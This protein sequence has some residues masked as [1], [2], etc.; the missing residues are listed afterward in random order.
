[1]VV[2]N[3]RPPTLRLTTSPDEMVVVVVVELS[4]RGC[5][6]I[7]L[8]LEVV[9]VVVFLDDEEADEEGSGDEG[10]EEVG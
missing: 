1:M 8:K 10:D 2:Q 4:K 7:E 9:V 6:S 5:G 3:S